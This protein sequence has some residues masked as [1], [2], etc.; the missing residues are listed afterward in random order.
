MTRLYKKGERLEKFGNKL[1]LS[2]F[3]V[4][5]YNDI[6]IMLLVLPR[7]SQQKT[8]YTKVLVLSSTMRKGLH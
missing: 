1:N 4:C 3:E 6:N 7:G 2:G 8:G 5:Y